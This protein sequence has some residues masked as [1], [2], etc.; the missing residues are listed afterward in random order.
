MAAAGSISVANQS[1]KG[2]SMSRSEILISAKEVVET[3]DQKEALEKLQSGDWISVNAI[4]KGE[5]IYWCLI[6]IS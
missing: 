2:G 1:G 5:D 4:Y 6:R 3:K